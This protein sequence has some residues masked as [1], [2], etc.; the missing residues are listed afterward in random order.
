VEVSFPTML[1]KHNVV[2]TFLWRSGKVSLL[3]LITTTHLSCCRC[4]FKLVS[5]PTVGCRIST[6]HNCKGHQEK[7]HIW[8]T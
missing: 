3:N 5:K 4:K 1:C 7:L 6:S 2:K 8:D